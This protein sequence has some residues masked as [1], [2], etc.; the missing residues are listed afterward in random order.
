[1][2]K[3]HRSTLRMFQHLPER[4]GSEAIYLLVGAIPLEATLDLRFL[5]LFGSIVRRTG[6]KVNSVLRRQLIMRDEQDTSWF[7]YI[8]RLLRKY[9]LPPPEDII[10]VIPSKMSW[11]HR[12]KAAVMN[13]W[14][15]ILMKGASEK[16][17]LRFLST[18]V[19]G[20]P[21]TVWQACDGDKR[22]VRRATIKAKL[23][24]GT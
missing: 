7:S 14:N 9:R 12:T 24:T 19:M 17:S 8:V 2:E 18:M 11:K 23:L 21:H 10:T 13:H 5:S 6:S 3:F 1:M 4:T 20:N 15:D 22:S 16:S